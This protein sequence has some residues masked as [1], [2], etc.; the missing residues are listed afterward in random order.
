MR[1]LDPEEL[2]R[3][4]FGALSHDGASTL[5]VQQLLQQGL[6]GLMHHPDKGLR[7][8]AKRFAA[9][10]LQRA[11]EAQVFAPDCEVLR[12]SA[13]RSINLDQTEK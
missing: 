11:T 8:A 4:E 6:S 12:R 13:D 10:G 3:D 1:P 7:E 2:L 9:V 5:E